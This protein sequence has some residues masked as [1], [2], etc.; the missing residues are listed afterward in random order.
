MDVWLVEG[1]VVEMVD[2]DGEVVGRIEEWRVGMSFLEF[3]ARDRC[4]LNASIS[5]HHFPG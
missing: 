2:W 3:M 5:F 1:V 4:S